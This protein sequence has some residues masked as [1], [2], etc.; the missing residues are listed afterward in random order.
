MLTGVFFHREF[1]GK[2]WPIV[3]N[4]YAGFEKIIEKFSKDPKIVVIEPE[5]VYEDDVVQVLRMY[6]VSILLM[7]NVRPCLAIE[8]KHLLDELDSYPA[9]IGIT[10]S[11]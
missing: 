8:L 4:R 6:R 11:Q 9:L 5:P 10:N 7:D 2:N 3:G 1:I